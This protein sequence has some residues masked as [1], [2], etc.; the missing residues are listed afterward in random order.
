MKISIIGAGNVGSALAERILSQ[1]LADVVL[2]DI[3]GG[4]AEAKA[5][6][7]SDASQLLGYKNKITGTD[8]YKEV[9]DSDVCVI[10]AGFPRL[11]GM[12]REDLIQK[13]S[14][15][16]KSVV[17]NIKKFSPGTVLIVVTNPLDIMTYAA[18][19]ES[20]F[21]RKKIIGM[22]GNLDAA[23]FANLLSRKL[24][25]PPDAIETYVL[26]SHGD[27]MVPLVSRT[28]I[29]GKP[30]RGLLG[31]KEIEALLERTKKRGGEI[32]RLLK[33]GSAY[34]SPSAAILEILKAIAGD[35]KKVIPCSCVLDGEYGLEGLALGVPARIGKNG[36]EEILEWDL[37][38]GELF[39]LQ[40]SAKAITR[41]TKCKKQTG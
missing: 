32:V 12:S 26:G 14:Q 11:P 7:I 39:L 18:Y 40:N 23:R 22:A 41:R 15:I 17:R 3:A 38:E 20:G 5:L 19:K 6:D 21:D 4:P 24:D 2:V 29:N 9:T 36:V 35:E 33:S 34:F 30:L 28:L 16:V 13:N 1:R 25:V 37:S 27:T 8:A 31:Q 10:T